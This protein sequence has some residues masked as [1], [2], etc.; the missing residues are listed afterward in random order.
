LLPP[1]APVAV[2]HQTKVEV[3]AAAPVDIVPE[4]YLVK[5]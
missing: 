4:H 3:V 5:D 1:A 2:K